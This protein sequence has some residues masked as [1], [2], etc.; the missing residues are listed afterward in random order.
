MD[1]KNYMRKNMETIETY[2][3]PIDDSVLQH[4]HEATKIVTL[5]FAGENDIE[6]H[7]GRRIR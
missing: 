4:C 7:I 2:S 6:C 3:Q 1:M 5:L